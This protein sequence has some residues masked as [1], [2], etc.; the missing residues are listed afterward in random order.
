MVLARW[1]VRDPIGEQGGINLYGYVGNSPVGYADAY[2]LAGAEA[3][4]PI[5]P[6]VGPEP[7]DGSNRGYWGDIPGDTDPALANIARAYKGLDR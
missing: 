6:G 1:P 2:G 4:G 7:G 3:E 5:I